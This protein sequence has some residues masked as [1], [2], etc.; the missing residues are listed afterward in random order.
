VNP[1]TRSRRGAGFYLG[2]LA[3]AFLIAGGLSYFASGDPDGLDTVT[4]D[5]CQLNSIGEPEG[6]TCIAQNA[7]DHPLAQ[8][9]FADY[10]LNGGA[11]T[12]G[13]AGIVGVVSTLALAGGLFWLLRPRG[14]DA[15]GAAARREE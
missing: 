8:T 9:P 15:A 6:G 5:G 11:G 12:V 2:F 10:A 1:P 7:E 14:S 3:V 13:L 4:L